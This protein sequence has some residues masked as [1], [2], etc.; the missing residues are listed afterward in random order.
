VGA[1]DGATAATGV[2]S[3]FLGALLHPAKTAIAEAINTK[4]N[5]EFIRDSK[6]KTRL[7]Y[8]KTV[9]TFE[10]MYFTEIFQ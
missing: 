5:F 7:Q 8:A 1:G 3:S 9:T 2:G 10:Q 4:T 6:E